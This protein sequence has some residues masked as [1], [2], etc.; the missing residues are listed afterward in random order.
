MADLDHYSGRAIE[1]A[2]PRRRDEAWIARRLASDEC[3]VAPVWRGKSLL[4]RDAAAFLPV[5]A[6]RR[7]L[8]EAPSEPIFLGVDEFGALFTLDL[9]HLSEADASALAPDGA[10]RELYGVATRLPRREASL[11]SHAAWLVHWAR[12]HRFCGA[13]GHPTEAREAGHVR[14]C[15][16]PDC[17]A[18]HFPRTDPAVIVAVEHEG[19]CLLAR[20]KGWPGR[21]HSCLAGFVEP[22]EAAEEAVARE[23]AEEAGLAVR[24]V[25]FLATQ[26]WPYPCSLML[27]FYATAESADLS[28]DDDELAEARWFGRDEL[29]A[30]NLDIELPRADSIARRLIDRWIAKG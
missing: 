17:G 29:T 5:R 25:R 30:A 16:N 20:Q 23:V 8:E 2:G 14:A 28:L 15:G 19:R 4:A 26:P 22:G 3:R 11:L 27:G 1:R 9:S 7:L 18:L 13:C 6:A 24:D 21:L 12:R 10:F